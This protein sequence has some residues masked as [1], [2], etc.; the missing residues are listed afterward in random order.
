MSLPSMGQG[1]RF[2][3]CPSLFCCWRIVGLKSSALGSH[4]ALT[5]FS[6]PSIRIILPIRSNQHPRKRF[7]IGSGSV[8]PRSLAEFTLSVSV[9]GFEMTKRLSCCHSESFGGLRI[10]SAKNLYRDKDS[11]QSRNESLPPDR[12]H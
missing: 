6:R 5:G 2:S 10:N 9:E 11:W 12:D 4:A 8:K 3:P 1:E 7:L